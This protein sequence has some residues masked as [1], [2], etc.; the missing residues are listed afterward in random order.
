[1]KLPVPVS[2]LKFYR[3]VR[4]TSTTNLQSFSSKLL[5]EVR[6]RVCCY[7]VQMTTMLTQ[8]KTFLIITVFFAHNVE[9]QY[10]EGPRYQF[11]CKVGTNSKGRVESIRE[12]CTTW[13]RMMKTSGSIGITS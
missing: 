3:N 10:N 1:M 6:E 7:F 5:L 9:T 13:N 4:P 11:Y 2:E 8:R 12:A